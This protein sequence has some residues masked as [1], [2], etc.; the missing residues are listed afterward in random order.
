MN[1]NPRIYLDK[2]PE[3]NKKT[4]TYKTFKK[5]QNPTWNVH[6]WYLHIKMKVICIICI[7]FL[8][9]SSLF[10]NILTIY[11]RLAANQM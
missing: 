1:K 6:Y 8:T 11:K 7:I 4:P 2:T 9:S 5:S 3:N 10:W